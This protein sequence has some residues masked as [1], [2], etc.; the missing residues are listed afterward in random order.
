M[1]TKQHN[2]VI[3]TMNNVNYAEWGGGGVQMY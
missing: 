1:H 3:I 2:N